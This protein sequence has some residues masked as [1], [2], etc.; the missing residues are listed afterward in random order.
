[1][2]SGSRPADNPGVQPLA[3]HPPRALLLLALLAAAATITPHSA[4]AQR[5]DART[6]GMGG[7]QV[8]GGGAWG[9]AS[10]VAY[11]GVPRDSSAHSEIPLPLGLIPVLADPPQFDPDKPDFNVYEIVNL[12]YNIPWNLQ[13]VSPQTP[14]NDISI[15]I[16][17]NQ[18]SVDLGDLADL[19]PKDHSRYAGIAT[20]PAPSFALRGVFIGVQPLIH[21][22]NDLS[23]NSALRG[24]LVDGD[25]VQTNTQY[26]AYDNAVGQVAAGLQLGWS[27]PVVRLGEN[28]RDPQSTALYVGGRVKLLRGIAFGSADNI[29]TI[30]TSDSL[31][32]S[33]PADLR[34]D[35]F[36]RDAMGGDGRW[37]VG[38]DLGLVW[39]SRGIEFGVGVNDVHT[40]LPWKVKETHVYTDTVSGDIVQQTLTEGVDFKSKVPTTVTLNAATRVGRWLV[41]AD[42][43]RGA[44]NTTAHAGGEIGWRGALLRCGASIDQEHSLQFGGGAGLRFGPVGFDLGL[45]THGRNLSHQRGL[46]LG[47]GLVLYH[48]GTP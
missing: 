26:T 35:A 22:D 38:L 47:A 5:L 25:A 36:T 2:K 21:Y 27:G 13:L 43:E 7:V 48:G 1:M 17:Q 32:G 42:I 34:Y 33:N 37:A 9:G 18:L 30:S 10:N 4:F 40:R 6:M 8:P 28:P 16:G 31:F 39:F 14:S 41:A 3:F 45:A 15:A 20:G 12:L 19:F 23:F 44:V 46:E 29:A 24:V 11:R